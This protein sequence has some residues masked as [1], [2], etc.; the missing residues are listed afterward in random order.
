MS[1]EQESSFSS[2]GGRRPNAGRKKGVPTQVTQDI[3]QMIR[4]ALSGAGGMDYLMQQSRENPV[5]FMG[6]IG[7]I[8]PKE[9]E[10]TISGSVQ[11]IN[12]SFVDPTPK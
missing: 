2:H 6:L 10:T 5:A 11:G 4:D 3:R 12:V 8:I 7:K 9:V 1:V